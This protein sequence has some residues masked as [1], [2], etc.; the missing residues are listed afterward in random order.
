MFAG[1]S[2]SYIEFPSNGAL[3]VQYSI[4]MLCWVYYTGASGPLFNYNKGNTAV[5]TGVRSL[6]SQKLLIHSTFERW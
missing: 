1:N 2:L 3:D 5:K 4:T 6:H